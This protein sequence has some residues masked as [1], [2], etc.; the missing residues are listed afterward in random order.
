MISR[1]DVEHIAELAD[2]GLAPE[3]VEE[4]THQFNL[5]LDYF[6]ILD[7]LPAEGGWTRTDTE[8]LNVMREDLVVPSLPQHEAI[9]NASAREDGFI[10]APRVM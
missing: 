8:D 3:E 10:K 2:I 4:F 7:Q 9:M 5:I 6:E 1:K